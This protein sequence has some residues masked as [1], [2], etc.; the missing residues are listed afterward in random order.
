L[1]YK[2]MALIKPIVLPIVFYR[3]NAVWLAL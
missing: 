1:F 3:N 2:A